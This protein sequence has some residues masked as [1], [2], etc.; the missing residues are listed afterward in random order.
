M[1]KPSRSHQ[2]YEGRCG[3]DIGVVRQALHSHLLGQRSTAAIL[4]P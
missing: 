2:D 4:H 3:G 1:L